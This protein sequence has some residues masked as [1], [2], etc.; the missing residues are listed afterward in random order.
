MLP[1]KC[2]IEKSQRHRRHRLATAHRNWS[3]ASPCPAY[4]TLLF[5]LRVGAT[6][7]KFSEELRAQCGCTANFHSYQN[8]RAIVVYL[9]LNCRSLK[10]LLIEES[11]STSRI[12][13]T[14]SLL[15]SDACPRLFILGDHF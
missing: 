14:S 12:M 9:F 2:D 3:Q 5:D 1:S 6:F 4:P 7:Q 15:L 13:I 8:L 11:S 10:F